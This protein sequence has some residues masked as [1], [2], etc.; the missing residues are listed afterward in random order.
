MIIDLSSSSSS[1]LYGR[2]LVKSNNKKRRKCL[3]Q[4]SG[5]RKDFPGAPVKVG[6]GEKLIIGKIS[7]IETAA[8]KSLWKKD[9]HKVNCLFLFTG[10]CEHVF[11]FSKW[12]SADLI[13]VWRT[14]FDLMRAARLWCHTGYL[15]ML[16]RWMRELTK[17]ENALLK[18][19]PTSVGNPTL[20]SDFIK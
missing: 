16:L 13:W 12:M 9:Q 3:N 18:A 15:R 1:Q 20:T 11:G 17:Q 7:Q 5:L 10:D 6:G 19:N 2:H 8:L 4:E 14:D